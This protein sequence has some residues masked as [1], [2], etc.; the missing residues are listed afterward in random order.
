VQ[1]ALP[2]VPPPLLTQLTLSE[3][4]YPCTCEFTHTYT[5]FVSPFQRIIYD[6]RNLSCLLVNRVSRTQGSSDDSL[7]RR[8][9]SSRRRHRRQPVRRS[10]VLYPA[11]D[12][13]TMR[14]LAI[15]CGDLVTTHPSPSAPT[16]DARNSGDIVIRNNTVTDFWRDTPTSAPLGLNKVQVI[17][18]VV[19][20][21]LTL[22]VIAL[23]FLVYRHRQG[24]CWWLV[25]RRGRLNFNSTLSGGSRQSSGS[26]PEMDTLYDA[27]VLYASA[28]QERVRQEIIN[29]LEKNNLGYR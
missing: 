14:A 21:A 10:T 25:G 20:A 11:L 15:E 9:S 5:N 7:R 6:F 1:T 2:A 22:V 8:R 23:A 19:M 28:D 17:V 16:T 27:L 26:E 24:L 13:Q 29:P 12:P 4:M 3:N 18:L